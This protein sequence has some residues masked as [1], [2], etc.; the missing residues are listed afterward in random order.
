MNKKIILTILT[1]FLLLTPFAAA[2]TIFSNWVGAGDEISIENDE[3][4]IRIQGSNND[5]VRITHRNTPHAVSYQDCSRVNQYR[6]CATNLSDE[7]TSYIERRNDRAE[8][9]IEVER[10]RPFRPYLETNTLSVPATVVKNSEIEVK[11]QLV[12]EDEESIP[13]IRYHVDLDGA[14]I[15]DASLHNVNGE[16]RD[17]LGM[18]RDESQKNV[19]YTLVFD[20]ERTY[21]LTET[22]EYGI[23]GQKDRYVNIYEIQSLDI[24]TFSIEKQNE[25]LHLNITSNIDEDITLSLKNYTNESFTLDFSTVEV[26]NLYEEIVE[27]NQIR[28]GKENLSL[29]FEVKSGEDIFTEEFTFEFGEEIEENV[30]NESVNQ[31][32]V[33]SNQTQEDVE[34]VTEDVS[35]VQ[36][37]L[38]WFSNLF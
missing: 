21:T 33:E 30:T 38:N 13:L 37:I 9:Y 10:H 11:K 24:Y 7:D 31:T 35:L 32:N 4:E 17:E 1:T 8:V 28:E 15:I 14:K 5:V 29:S 20:E 27:V 2:D 36:R 34:E 3:F 16:L 22:V 18:A 6:V 25:S 19:S 26:S 23:V 12:K